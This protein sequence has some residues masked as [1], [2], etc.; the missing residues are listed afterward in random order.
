MKKLLMLSAALLIAGPA[1]A[2]SRDYPGTYHPW[3]G[4]GY[5]AGDVASGPTSNG[6]G[7]SANY[8]ISGTAADFCQLDTADASNRAVGTNV[9]ITT[10]ANS[11][12][13]SVTIDKFQGPNDFSNAWFSH[14][15]LSNSICNTNFSVTAQSTN[16]GLWNPTSA[17]PGTQFTKLEDY[18]I[19]VAFGLNGQNGTTLASAAKASPA[20]LISNGDPAKGDFYFEFNGAANNSLALLAGTYS[21]TV[22]ITMTP[23][24]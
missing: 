14:I 2:G 1:L 22:V 24:T 4:P 15:D 13:G 21:D 20:T 11:A 8:S 7:T 17:N 5:V 12:S 19:K 23:A 16:G 3:P 18:S 6:V 9:T 10:T